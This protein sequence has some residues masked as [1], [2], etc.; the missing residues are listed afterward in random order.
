MA[1]A[2]RTPPLVVLP[3]I[4]T[5]R[6][7]VIVACTNCRKRKVKCLASENPPQSSCKRCLEK[8][9]VCEYVAVGED[10]MTRSQ[11]L[12]RVSESPV[13][14]SRWAPR[15][16]PA[17]SSSSDCYDPPGTGLQRPAYPDSHSHP[18][19][20]PS[21]SQYLYPHYP[22]QSASNSARSSP[23][24]A[25]VYNEPNLSGTVLMQPTSSPRIGRT[26]SQPNATDSARHLRHLERRRSYPAPYEVPPRAK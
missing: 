6:R 5:Q 2:N 11:P 15:N 19:P 21:N 14:A 12:E 9:I 3:S 10:K 1:D 7:R 16:L 26:P 18:N 20:A 23:R 24:P 4:F 13:Y 25:H 22:S 8:G 17:P